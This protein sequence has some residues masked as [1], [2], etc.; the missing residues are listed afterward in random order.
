[1]GDSFG[2][3][4]SSDRRVGFICQGGI[5]PGH[6]IIRGENGGHSV[7]AGEGR[8]LMGVWRWKG[9]SDVPLLSLWFASA[10]GF[11]WEGRESR[12]RVW[13]DDG[14]LSWRLAVARGG[15]VNG[16]SQDVIQ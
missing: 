5:G 12:D 2:G 1:M 16:N 8:Q 10:M 11:K 14:C 4:R 15:V 3:S 7:A 9:G 6:G 13:T